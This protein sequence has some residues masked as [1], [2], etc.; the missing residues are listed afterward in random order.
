MSDRI[1]R[2]N[3]NGE[4]EAYQIPTTSGGVTDAGKAVGTDAN[5]KIDMSFMPSG[6]GLDTI[7]LV[8]SEALTDGDFVNIWDDAGTTK[9]RKADNTTNTKKAD[10]FVLSAVTSGGNAV[11]YTEGDNNKLTG[12]TI[13][14]KYFLGTI[15][16][17][18]ATAPT[19]SGSI[20]QPLG[21]V[22]NATTIRFEQKEYIKNA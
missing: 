8:A 14:T 7:T 4:T 6:L 9:V 22:K 17:A 3:T 18:S 11:V 16:S 5:G 2:I 19:T 13:G 15:G 1:L 10:G 20:I 12:L 21:V